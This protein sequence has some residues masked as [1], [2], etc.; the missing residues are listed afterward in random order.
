[1]R[2]NLLVDRYGRPLTHIRITVTHRCNYRCIFCHH[3]GEIEKNASKELKP[4]HYKLIAKALNI[5]NIRYIKITGGEPLIREDIQD[6]LHYLK[7]YGNPKEISIVTNG[8]YLA[9]KIGYIRHYVDR[10]NVSIH[11]LIE[12]KYAKITGVNG[13]RR[14]LQGVSK[15]ISLGLHVKVNIVVLKE[16]YNEI[17]NMLDYLHELGVREVNLIELI[18]LGLS[19]E[20]YR[21]LHVKLEPL[22]TI[23]K[24]RCKGVSIRSFHNR[25]V[26]MLKNRLKVELV[27]SY[28][29]RLF[30]MGC[31][32]IRL[33]PYGEL[34]PCL[35]RNDNLIDL[36]RILWTEN[37]SEDDKVKL[38]VKGFI[39]A[40]KLRE[41]YFK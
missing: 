25:P 35:F 7:T 30:C 6:I 18:P 27:K 12:E 19:R 17:P 2:L 22:E 28:G 13:L 36:G 10:V 14:V 9:E 37:L 26:Y 40:N 8:Y 1:M 15:C 5:L 24:A 32:R 38:I 23:L 20:Q 33:T 16:N 11:S 3:E 21:R 39:E 41:P 34:K 31:T 29:N 4:V